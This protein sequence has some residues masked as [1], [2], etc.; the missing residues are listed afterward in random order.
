MSVEAVVA[1]FAFI[2]LFIGWVILPS[3][4]KK[5]HDSTSEEVAEG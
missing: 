3:F 4:I 1:I 2:A 5:H